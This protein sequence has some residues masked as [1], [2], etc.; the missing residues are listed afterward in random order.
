MTCPGCAVYVYKTR[1]GRC[2]A[3]GADLSG[4]FKRGFLETKLEGLC[5]VVVDTVSVRDIRK[6][7]LKHLQVYRLPNEVRDR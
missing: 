5:V 1:E 6:I 7:H 3:C 4:D 2:L